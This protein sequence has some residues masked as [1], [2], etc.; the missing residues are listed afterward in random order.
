MRVGAFKRAAVAAA[1]SII[2]LPAAAQP[3]AG[4]GFLFSPPSAT[5]TVHGG[6]AQPLASGGVFSLARSELTLGRSDF[7]AGNVGFDLSFSVA[8]RLELV[9]GIDR[10]GSSTR[11]EYRDWLDNNDQ[12]IEQTTSLRRAPGTAS[13]RYFLADR[14]RRIGTVAWVPARFVPFVSVGAGLMKY[15]FDQV[16]D[17]IDLGTLNVFSAR[18]SSSGWEPL[19]QAGAGAQMNLNQRFNLTGEIRYVRASGDGNAPNGD[20]SGYRVNLSGVSTLIGF[21]LRL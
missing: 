12:P 4:K 2:S 17:F 18:L 15:R 3:G 8:P 20:F 11:S 13:V 1:C 10:S 19:L 21:T 9:V 6:F 16:G 5:L 14:G 7:A